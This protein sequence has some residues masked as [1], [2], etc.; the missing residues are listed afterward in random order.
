MTAQTMQ[1]TVTAPAIEANILSQEFINPPS[2]PHMTLCVLRLRNGFAV[3][4]EAAPADLANFD[5]DYGRQL[6]RADAIRKIWP[7]E[8]YLLRETLSQS[9]AEG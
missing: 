2:V 4:G 3:I 6:A 7:F 5:A 1:N 9:G 8:G